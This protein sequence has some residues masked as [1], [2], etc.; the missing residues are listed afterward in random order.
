M[1]CFYTYIE[2]LIQYNP[3]VSCEWECCDVYDPGQITFEQRLANNIMSLSSE[4]ITAS[5]ERNTEGSVVYFSKIYFFKEIYDFST[6]EKYI[7]SWNSTITENTIISASK[8]KSCKKKFSTSDSAQITVSQRQ[9]DILF[10]DSSQTDQ[11]EALNL[12]KDPSVASKASNSFERA[13]RFLEMFKDQEEYDEFMA[14]F[15]KEILA[16]D[17]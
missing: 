1:F 17:H 15:H 10:L 12:L 6:F 4:R 2:E 9:S 16:R 7:S 8:I 11:E 5:I 14:G 3:N 13:K